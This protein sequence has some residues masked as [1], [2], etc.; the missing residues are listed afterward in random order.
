MSGSTLENITPEIDSHLGHFGHKGVDKS[1]I[2]LFLALSPEDRLS[3]NDK[4][5]QAL[6]EL[7]HAFNQKA[8][9]S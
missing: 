2:K 4:T 7:K 6:T 1:L 9:Q 8:S 5:I 3:S